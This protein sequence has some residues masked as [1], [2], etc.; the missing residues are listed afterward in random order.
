MGQHAAG[1]EEGGGAFSTRPAHPQIRLKGLG[2]G[3]HRQGQRSHPQG[4]GIYRQG[5]GIYPQGQG[6]HRQ[7]QRSHPQGQGIH[8]Q[9]QR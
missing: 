1:Q 9:G 6:I 2:Q 5:Q 4:Q 7:G 8:P 3:I